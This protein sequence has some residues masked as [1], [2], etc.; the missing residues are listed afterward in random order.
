LSAGDKLN[1]SDE[2]FEVERMFLNHSGYTTFSSS[3][4]SSTIKDLKYDFSCLNLEKNKTLFLGVKYFGS[5]EERLG[6]IEL[7]ISGNNTVR[8]IRT[9]IQ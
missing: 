2:S 9:A 5:F 1:F 6:W 4:T 7:E 3:P 8:L